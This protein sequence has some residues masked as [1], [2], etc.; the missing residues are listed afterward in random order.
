[1]GTKYKIAGRN[2]G[3]KYVGRFRG[4]SLWHR[5]HAKTKTEAINKMQK[6]TRYKKSEIIVKLYSQVV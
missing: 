3:G 4:S 2:Y 5:I 1:M 6:G